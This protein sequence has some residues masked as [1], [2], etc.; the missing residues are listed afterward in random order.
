MQGNQLAIA[1]SDGQLEVRACESF[2]VISQIA[3]KPSSLRN[4][5]SDGSE[6]VDFSAPEPKRRRLNDDTAAPSSVKRRPDPEDPVFLC[7]SP[8]STC[9]SVLRSSRAVDMYHLAPCVIGNDE[10]GTLFLSFLS[11]HAKFPNSFLTF[12]LDPLSLG[13]LIADMYE[14][15]IVKGLNS[16]DISALVAAIQRY[17]KFSNVYR[18]ILLKLMRDL[19]AMT[20]DQQKHYWRPIEVIKATLYR[21]APSMD[22]N[23]ANSQI[24]LQLAHI[25]DVS[26]GLLRGSI[27]TSPLFSQLLELQELIFLTSDGV[28]HVINTNPAK[29]FEDEA[30]PEGPGEDKDAAFSA[31]P[32]EVVRSCM[33]LLY[34]ITKSQNCTFPLPNPP[35]T[36]SNLPPDFLAA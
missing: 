5:R 16:W 10:K 36:I 31:M 14:L 25:V 9:L 11:R 7:P 12:R 13:L 19:S 26:K 21:S 20:P 18:I 2:Q 4:G 35:Q 34:F 30:I 3:A 32:T 29:I 6:D 23:Y 8:N 15:S 22:V 28:E 17:P 27:R 33:Q 1:L 24:R